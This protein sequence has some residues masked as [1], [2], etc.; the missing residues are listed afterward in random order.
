M[1]SKILSCR[2]NISGVERKVGFRKRIERR[3]SRKEKETR[4]WFIEKLNRLY[5]YVAFFCYFDLKDR[6]DFFLQLIFQ[7][8]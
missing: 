6:L 8:I 4:K 3:G 2:G 5:I 7:M 1:A